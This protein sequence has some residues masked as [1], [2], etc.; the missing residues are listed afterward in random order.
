V[1]FLESIECRGVDPVSETRERAQEA[2]S[3]EEDGGDFTW[4]KAHREAFF[5]TS[6]GR[7]FKVGV[8]M[9]R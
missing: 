4:Y 3:A 5:A 6:A 2:E 1:V 7:K 9:S 8:T